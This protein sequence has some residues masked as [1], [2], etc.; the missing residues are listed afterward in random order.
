M[1]GWGRTDIH[2][3][4]LE[5]ERRTTMHAVGLGHL[6]PGE[7]IPR[8]DAESTEQSD[9]Q[10]SVACKEASRSRIAAYLNKPRIYRGRIRIRGRRSHTSASTGTGYECTSHHAKMKHG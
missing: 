9:R 6:N 1:R 5:T 2:K 8:D 10:R 3:L 4:G 7:A